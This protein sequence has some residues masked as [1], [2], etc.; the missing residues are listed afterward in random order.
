MGQL[1][2]AFIYTVDPQSSVA[3][4]H[5]DWC[6]G[7]S[8]LDHSMPQVVEY[9]ADLLHRFYERWGPYQWRNDSGPIA[10]RDGDDTSLLAQQ[11]GFMEVLRRFLQAH[12]DCAFQ[13]VNGGGMALNWE[14]L[15]YA[16]GFQFTDGQA[17]A[18]ANYY[19]S[20][21]FPPD[22]I[23]NMPDIWD[24]AKYDPATWRGLLCSNFDL[25]GDT[26]DPAKLE[27]LRDLCDVYHYL[28]SRRVVGRWVRT[29]H[30]VITGDDEDAGMGDNGFAGRLRPRRRPFASGQRRRSKRVSRAKTAPQKRGPAER[31]T[32]GLGSPQLFRRRS[33]PHRRLG[34]CRPPP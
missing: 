33:S 14:Y 9:E 1:I 24:P 11:Q 10:P 17:Q 19:A 28:E 13:G 15:S 5:P 23:N 31:E 4:T 27:G 32:R 20:Y 8:T 18:L 16:S 12:P 26:F 29:Y 21:L 25:T 7:G 2:Y 22:K 34:R 6:I 3:L 30:P